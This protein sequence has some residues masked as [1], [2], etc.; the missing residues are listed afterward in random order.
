MVFHAYSIDIAPVRK[1]KLVMDADDIVIT[2]WVPASR[3]G[4][5]VVIWVT[6]VQLNPLGTY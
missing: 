3:K 2:Y 6:A 4:Y 1:L 5:T